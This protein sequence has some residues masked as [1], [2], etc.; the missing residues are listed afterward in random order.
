MS[1]DSNQSNEQQQQAVTIEVEDDNVKDNN[2]PESIPNNSTVQTHINIPR[3]KVTELTEA[4]RNQLVSDAQAGVENPFYQVKLFKNGK[5]RI[6]LRKQSKAQ[7][8]INEAQFNQPLPNDFK[9]YYTDQQLLMEHII[10]LE[11]SFNALRSKHKKLKKRYNELEGYLYDDEEQTPP[12]PNN[13]KLRGDIV[14]TEQVPVN[15]NVE[16]PN[17]QPIPQAIPQPQVQHRF[18]KSWRQLNNNH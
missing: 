16:Q 2:I 1:N 17:E 13:N 11:T 14:D 4:E 6:C 12:H 8:V 5:T 3:K 18:V 10:N 7:Q 9:R 15:P